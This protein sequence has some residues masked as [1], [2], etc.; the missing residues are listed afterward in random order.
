M[1]IIFIHGSI[2]APE[3]AEFQAR[4]ELHSQAATKL[5]ATKSSTMGAFEESIEKSVNIIQSTNGNQ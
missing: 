2:I 5:G 1:Q 3:K 4:I